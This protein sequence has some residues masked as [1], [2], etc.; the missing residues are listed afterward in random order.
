M[1][2]PVPARPAADAANLPRT[3]ANLPHSAT[4]DFPP[5][6][7][8]VIK[9]VVVDE[10]GHG[11]FVDEP[12]GVAVAGFWPTTLSAVTPVSEDTQDLREEFARCW[13]GDDDPTDG[14]WREIQADRAMGVVEPVLSELREQLAVYVAKAERA[15]GAQLLGVEYG[16]R[17]DAE[18]MRWRELLAE[19][20]GHEDDRG[21][22]PHMPALIEMVA[23]LRA[24]RDRAR[25]DYREMGSERDDR[26]MKVEELRR[27]IE[28]LRGTHDWM[29]EACRLTVADAAIVR[30][31][32]GQL[33]RDAV[34]AR[35]KLI[36]LIGGDWTVEP[37][38]TDLA[39]YAARFWGDDRRDIA[40]LRAQLAG[41]SRWSERDIALLTARMGTGHAR[42]VEVDAD[43]PRGQRMARDMAQ[44]GVPTPGCGCGHDGMGRG[45]HASD[46]DWVKGTVATIPGDAADGMGRSVYVRIRDGEVDRS[47]CVNACIN[48][49]RDANGGLLGV[50]VLGAVSVEIDHLDPEPADSNNG[51]N[52]IAPIVTPGLSSANTPAA[53]RVRELSERLIAGAVEVNGVSQ[54]KPTHASADHGVCDCGVLVPTTEAWERHREAVRQRADDAADALTQDVYVPQGPL[55][56][57]AT[58][59][60]RA[61]DWRE[62]FEA[63]QHLLGCIWLYVDWRFLTKQMTTAQKEMWADA[64]DNFGDPADRGPKADRWWR[65]D[66]PLVQGDTQPG[67]Q[68]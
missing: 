54:G 13:D 44:S 35:A 64:V 57:P 6:T 2:E 11:R 48:L 61:P 26:Q 50:E 27:E 38:L 19:A 24:E 45:W 30:D 62:N 9:R 32:R 17:V 51:E 42:V 23:E 59:T 53:T 68:S 22:P 52:F 10:N 63:A 8:R 31:Q 28:R 66:A 55:V 1:T 41:Q 25:R 67:G 4:A 15:R 21:V 49:D 36:G 18:R 60:D 5:G 3:T 34:S 29:S 46:C 58:I 12:G 37:S 33:H 47:E 56:P 20:L 39:T 65:D 14:T 40:A 7:Y 16:K 43:S